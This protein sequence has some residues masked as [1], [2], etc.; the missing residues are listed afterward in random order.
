MVRRLS[1]SGIS[2]NNEPVA[3]TSASKVKTQQPDSS[4]R[5]RQ[6][7]LVQIEIIYT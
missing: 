4:G 3:F 2:N 6:K 7:Y 1:D 5:V